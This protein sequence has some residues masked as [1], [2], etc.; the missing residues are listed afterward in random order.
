[1]IAPSI[2]ALATIR[3]VLATAKHACQHTD[4]LIVFQVSASSSQEKEYLLEQ[5]PGYEDLSLFLKKQSTNEAGVCSRLCLDTCI[6]T[7]FS[8][9]TLY[10]SPMLD[11]FSLHT[12]VAV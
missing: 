7:R 11:A 4:Y 3:Y 10:L 2:V 8:V 6:S 9:D 5:G 12:R 1:M